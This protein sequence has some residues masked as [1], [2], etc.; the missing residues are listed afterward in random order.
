M[1]VIYLPSLVFKFLLWVWDILL[2]LNDFDIFFLDFGLF[3][4]VL[5][6]DRILKFIVNIYIYIYFFFW[7]LWSIL[8]YFDKTSRTWSFVPSTTSWGR[9]WHMIDWMTVG[10]WWDDTLNR[11]MPVYWRTSNSVCKKYPQVSSE[12]CSWMELAFWSEKG[13]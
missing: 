4:Y 1:P 2:I 11:T 8:I 7:I 5:I 13:S 10:N 12:F 3:W 6:Q 9:R